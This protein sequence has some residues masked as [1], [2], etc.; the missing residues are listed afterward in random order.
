[1]RGVMQSFMRGVMRGV[2]IDPMWG[3]MSGVLRG[4]MRGVMRGVMRDLQFLTYL[5][6]GVIRSTGKVSFCFIRYM[7]KYPVARTPFCAKATRSA[8]K[9]PLIVVVIL[10]L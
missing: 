4:F 5:Q 6:N 1:M 8:P 10:A 3:V 2:M 9:S 7:K